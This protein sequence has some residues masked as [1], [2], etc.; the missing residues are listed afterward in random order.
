MNMSAVLNVM[1]PLVQEF[2][3]VGP[4]QV[5][6]AVIEHLPNLLSWGMDAVLTIL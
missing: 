6:S 5:A 3:G 1:E 2:V 4:K